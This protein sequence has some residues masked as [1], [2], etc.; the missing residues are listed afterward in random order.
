MVLVE[1]TE[2]EKVGSGNSKGERFAKWRQNRNS[3]PTAQ[4]TL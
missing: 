2:R 3:K 1:I 4:T